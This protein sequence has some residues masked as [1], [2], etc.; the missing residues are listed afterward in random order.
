[1]T[2]V[3]AALAVLG[4]VAW[5]SSAAALMALG[6]GDAPPP[7]E[8]PALDGATVSSGTLA[9]AP[10]A[11]LFWSTWSP[12]SAEMLADFARYQESYGPKGLRIVAVNIDAERLDEARRAAVR[13]YAAS[14]GLPFPVLVDEG[15][16]TFAAWGVEA[17]PTEVLL[18]A[19]GRIAYTLPG[20]PPSLRDE[21][22]EAIER[23][24]GVA[25][26]PAPPPPPP[27]ANPRALMHFNLGRRFLAL[28]DAERA[29]ASFRR[30][31][32]EDPAFLEAAVMEARLS[33]ATG[34]VAAGE[35]IARRLAP[36]A[37]NRADL[38]WLLGMIALER[39]RVA[40][41]GAAFSALR[42]R[43]PRE[44]W[45]AWG[46]ALVALAE[47][48][49]AAAG[50]LLEEGAAL[51]PEN[52]EGEAFVR[53]WFRERWARGEEVPGEDGFVAALPRLG[54]LRD[55]YRALRRV[56]DGE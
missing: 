31:A 24:L 11:V 39:G 40:E 1:M 55:R 26:P 2:R 7:F 17:H 52:P 3:L 4:A 30:S 54:D 38:R 13:D 14:R 42:E 53:G 36:E 45:G 32:G 16:R 19:D 20:Y 5:P 50:P 27:A 44:G 6:V 29:L 23:L 12:R 15:L 34:D 33:L 37:V 47:G 35:G 41:A 9:G 49:P 21:L 51:L 8:L 46:L 48:D 28:G 43:H 22:R 25:P 18:G 56:A 10:A